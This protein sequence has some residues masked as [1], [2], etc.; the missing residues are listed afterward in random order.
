LLVGR[1]GRELL[2]RRHVVTLGLIPVTLGRRLMLISGGVA[3]PQSRLLVHG[4]CATVRATG[5]QVTA[6]RGFVRGLRSS[7]RRVGA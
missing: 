3:G 2:G 7:Q 4:R 1:L 5:V 6:G